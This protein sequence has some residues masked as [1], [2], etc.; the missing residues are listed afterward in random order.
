MS[1]LIRGTGLK[2]VDL[3]SIELVGTD[4]DADPL[5][6]LRATRTGN[7]IRA[8]FAKDDAFATLDT[9][10]P[11]EVHVITIRIAGTDKELTDRIRVVGRR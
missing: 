7:H 1:A 9:P 3:T 10:K 6:A 5:P 8:F 11:G 2:D 4:P